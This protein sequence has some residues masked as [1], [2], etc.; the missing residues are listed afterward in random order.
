MARIASQSKGGYYSTP[1]EELAFI[2]EHLYF[3]RGE[4][5]KLLNLCDPCAGE[6]KALHAIGNHFNRL[7]ADVQTYAVELEITRANMAREVINH[8]IQ[9]GYE[10]VRTDPKYSL[11]W[12]NPVYDEV[13]HERTELRFLRTLTSKSKNVLQQ[14][15]LLMF[16]VPQYVL[17]AC[18]SVLAGRFHNVQVYRFTDKNY[19]I[20]QQVVVFGYYGRAKLDE[21]KEISARL[22][23][24]AKSGPDILPTLE[25]IE[26]DFVVK[27]SL[28]EVN[29]FRA[30]KLKPEEIV[31]DLQESSVFEEFSKRIS[32]KSNRATM[33]NPILPLKPTH[34]GIAVAS[35]AI[36][37]NMG[38]HLVT[39]ITKP[40]TDV[41]EEFDDEGLK[42]REIY[43]KHHK[44][45]V[46]VFTQTGIH[47]LE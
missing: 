9:D 22:K 33:K 29:V 10:N 36:S 28:E 17:G 38:N 43:I 42:K 14:N 46:R 39:G 25:D 1:L 18:A 13:F 4:E 32:Q 20:F 41:E 21:R 37:G 11:M 5:N 40:V 44:S 30:G 24:F 6:G 3:E 7:G 19:P 34:M 15:G 2:F 23:E 35:G 45:I 16:C 27:A 26:E 31:R 47:E 12:L 8:V